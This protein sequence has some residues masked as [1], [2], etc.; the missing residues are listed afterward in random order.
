MGDW[1]IEEK[2]EGTFLSILP[3]MGALKV[4]AVKNFRFGIVNNVMLDAEGC[5]GI[6]V[7][8]TGVDT[9]GVD[10]RLFAE[11][12]GQMREVVIHPGEHS[13]AVYE[14]RNMTCRAGLLKV[15]I[16]I[17]SPAIYITMGN[18]KVRKEVSRETDVLYD[19]A[20]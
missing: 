20:K 18:F 11:N 7:E 6:S 12:D 10:V 1:W 3:E 16:R 9:T 15:G 2:E 19:C 4:Q 13:R 17:S 8:I 14:I 5:Y